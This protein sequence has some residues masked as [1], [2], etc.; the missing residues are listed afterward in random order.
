MTPTS[1]SQDGG[2][3]GFDRA[4]ADAS[5]QA[6]LASD[7]ADLAAGPTR[8]GDQGPPSAWLRHD[9]AAYPSSTDRKGFRPRFARSCSGI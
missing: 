1:G 7:Q 9:L 6:D 2:W 5:D 3:L 4:S 8:P